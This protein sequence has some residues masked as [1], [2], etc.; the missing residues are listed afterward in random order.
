MG[1][2]RRRKIGSK[3]IRDIA[4]ISQQSKMHQA[5]D[6]VLLSFIIGAE[7][8]KLTEDSIRV[9]EDEK[10]ESQ[11]GNSFCGAAPRASS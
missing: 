9:P 5:N 4:F 8:I 1:F 6:W 7:G 2:S 11:E 10:R 3:D